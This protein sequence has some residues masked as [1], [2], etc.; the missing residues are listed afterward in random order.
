MLVLAVQRGS[1]HHLLEWINLA[2]CSAGGSKGGEAVGGRVVGESDSPSISS[3]IFSDV[4]QQM[5]RAP[6]SEMLFG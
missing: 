3:K 5:S 6:V 1:L 2:L 4:L